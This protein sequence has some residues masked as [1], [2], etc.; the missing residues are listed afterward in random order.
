MRP[1]PRLIGGLRSLFHKKQVEQELDDELRA[2]LET[3]VDQKMSAG[4]S[5]EQAVR[6][7]RIEL[8]G[9]EAT[10]ERVRH[11]GWETLVDS[12]WQDVRYA[13]RGLRASPGFAAIAILTLALGISANT[14]IFS[15]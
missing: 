11:V 1:L 15:V 5:R 12:L 10:K 3:A 4:M 7:A 13:I 9:V 6:A 8:G 14:A 2:Y